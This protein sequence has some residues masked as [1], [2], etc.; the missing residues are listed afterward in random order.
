MR[1]RLI[2]PWVGLTTTA[3]ALAFLPFFGLMSKAAKVY[4]PTFILFIASSLMGTYLQR[5]A[6][7]Y[8]SLY[9]VPAHLPFGI[10]EIG[11][12]LLYLGTWGL[13]YLAFMEAFPKM[14]I[15][16]QTSP[17]RDEVQI[18]VDPRTMEPLPAHE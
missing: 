6:E 8:P 16:L 18:P 12:G 10:W 1:L 13:S 7:V 2:Q 9:G 11:I 4:L 3:A 17:Y 15:V 5:Y 14:R